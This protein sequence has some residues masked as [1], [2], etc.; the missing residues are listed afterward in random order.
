ME[1][2]TLR[3]GDTFTFDPARPVAADVGRHAARELL[4]PAHGWFAEDLDSLDLK[5]ARRLLDEL[6][7]ES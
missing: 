2:A 3:V 5:D 6:A 7:A 1:K 4:A